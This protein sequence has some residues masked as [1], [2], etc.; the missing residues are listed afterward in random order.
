MTHSD[1]AA[2]RAFLQRMGHLGLAG[3]AAPWALNLAAMGEAAAFSASDGYKALVCIFLYGGNDNGNTVI[4]VD[5][6][7][8]ADYA[9]L[10]GSLALGKS[11]LDATRLKPATPLPDG[12]EYALAPSLAPLVPLFHAGRL[13]VQLN[14]GP[15]V[16]PTTVAQYRN[17]T[18]PLPPKLFSHNDQQSVWQSSHAEGSTRGWGGALGDLAIGGNGSGASFTCIS[19]SGNAVFLAGNKAM[20][21]RVSTKGAVPIEPFSDWFCGKIGSCGDAL[22]TLITQP[23]TNLLERELGLLAQRAISSQG[24]VAAA[25]SSASRSA[26]AFSAIPATN[27]L[28][29]QLRVVAQMIEGRAVL[30]N[31][32]Q[33]FMVSMTGYDTH[34]N[35]SATHPVLLARLGEAMAAFQQSMTDIGMAERVTSFTAS[36]FGRTLSSNGG[37]SD[38]GWGGHHFIMGGAVDGGKFVGTAPTT[39]L[40]EGEDVGRGALLPT[41]SVDQYAATLAQWFG[42]AASDLPLLLPNIGNFSQTKLATFKV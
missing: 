13:A 32:R 33:V 30:G 7:G 12:R 6:A 37:G 4:P 22:R 1:F 19:A 35:L 31:T 17:Q 39:R 2:R 29:A 21:Y 28:A 16:Q 14:V 18:V 27:K 15:L 5:A 36:E 26:N 42:A 40:N 25:I 10:R 38:H 11:A 3:V 20:P 8:Y 34:D 24:T 23:R 9:R 41:T